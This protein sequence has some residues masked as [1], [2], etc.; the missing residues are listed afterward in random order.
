MSAGGR[1]AEVA[2]SDSVGFVNLVRQTGAIAGR[3]G[4][5]SLGYSLLNLHLGATL[6]YTNDVF[7]GELTPKVKIDGR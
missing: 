4:W 1:V 7:N 2:S 3:Q 5:E 6:G